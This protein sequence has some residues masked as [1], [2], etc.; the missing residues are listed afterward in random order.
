M[1]VLIEEWGTWASRRRVTLECYSVVTWC[2]V[3]AGYVVQCPV[4]GLC[5]R[6]QCVDTGHCLTLYIMSWTPVSHLSQPPSGAASTSLVWLTSS[7][8]DAGSLCGNNIYD[9]W[10]WHCSINELLILT[11]H[12]KVINILFV[13]VSCTIQMDK[14]SKWFSTKKLHFSWLFL[15]V[16][17]GFQ[18]ENL[19]LILNMLIFWKIF[20]RERHRVTMVLQLLPET[21]VLLRLQPAEQNTNKNVPL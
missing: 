17:W 9:K 16:S 10:Q 21:M 15:L 11:Q 8:H 1:S 12:F 3:S 19:L 4:P 18:S 13:E 6:C 14:L 20:T 2:R 7:E 5:V